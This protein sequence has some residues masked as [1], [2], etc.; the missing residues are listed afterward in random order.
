MW[1]SQELID[2]TEEVWSVRYGRS[3]AYDEIVEI[4]LNV[5]RWAET[6]LKLHLERQRT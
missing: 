5:K 2:E 3:L 6:V 1:I 4:L